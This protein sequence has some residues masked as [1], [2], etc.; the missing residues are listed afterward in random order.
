M[1]AIVPIIIAPKGSI[2]MSATAPTATPPANVA[3]CMCT[4]FSR[5]F[6]TNNEIMNVATHDDAIAKNV[7]TMALVCPSSTAT[8][9]LKDG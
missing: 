7:L 3:F 1:P 2:C 9:E 8:A 5:P 6:P 4:I